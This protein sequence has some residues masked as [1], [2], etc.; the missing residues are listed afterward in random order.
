M[1]IAE[2]GDCRCP[3]TQIRVGTHPLPEDQLQQTGPHIRQFSESP[4]SETTSNPN[5]KGTV[6]QHSEL[7]L[8]QSVRRELIESQ[9]VVLELNDQ[10]LQKQT[11]KADAI[12]LLCQA[13]LMLEQKISHIMELDRVLNLQITDLKSSQQKIESDKAAISTKLSEAQ[14][15]QAQAD[16][17]I[18]DLTKRLDE[19]NREIGQT[20][21][22]AGEINTA[23]AASKANCDDLKKR[24]LEQTEK[25]KTDTD[26]L[27]QM[28][29]E[30]DKLNRL[31]A[32][33]NEALAKSKVSEGKSQ[34][35][36][37]ELK[38]SRTWRWT[39]I[40]RS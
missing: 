28:E 26:Q 5:S 19:A 38:N 39:R 14:N 22:M 29:R 24:N 30:I 18:E 37:T 6:S 4:M 16:S 13:E 36:L 12:A 15:A 27:K 2:N 20:H 7:E 17:V 10:I 35:E 33:T 21:E 3:K 1:V 32:T 11:D 34:Q 9:L 8:V 25:I 40:F 31:L 23:L